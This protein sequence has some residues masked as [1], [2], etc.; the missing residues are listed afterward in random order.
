MIPGDS[1]VFV[2]RLHDARWQ[3]DM[4]EIFEIHPKLREE[5]LNEVKKRK[6]QN[7]QKF[8]GAVNR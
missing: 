2:S 4:V 7:Q 8:Q 3:D 1:H 5:M 6:E